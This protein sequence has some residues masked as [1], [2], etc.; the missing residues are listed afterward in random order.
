M[1][2]LRFWGSGG[3]GFLGGISSRCIF[4]ELPTTTEAGD[5][6]SEVEGERRFNLEP[7]DKIILKEGIVGI[8]V[9]RCRRKIISGKEGGMQEFPLK[10][11]FM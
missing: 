3:S 10:L 9:G 5:I 8:V 2:V 11:D 7:I 4:E 1:L 6:P